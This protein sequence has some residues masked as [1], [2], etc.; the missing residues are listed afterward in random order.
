MTI[1]YIEWRK[2][3]DI[4]I[5][6]IEKL[7]SNMLDE[8]E[9]LLVGQDTSVMAQELKKKTV[10]MPNIKICGTVPRQKIHEILDSCDMLIC[11]S[12][13]DPMPTVCAE[14]MMHHVPCL[15]SDATG[16]SEYINDGYDG[17]I[18][19]GEDAKELSEKIIWSIKN[20][21]KLSGIGDRSYHIYETVFSEKAFEGKLLGYVEG[22]IGKA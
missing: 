12:R 17:F 9:F 6:A 7:P 3:Q 8:A 21:D 15:V 20:H 18:F 1:G 5:E 10:D 14:A 2:G 11:P 4:L 16:T 13:E 19:K 22:M